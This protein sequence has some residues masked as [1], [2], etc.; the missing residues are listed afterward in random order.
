[1]VAFEDCRRLAIWAMTA[2]VALSPI[3]APAQNFY[4]GKTLTVIVGTDAGG[5]YDIYG[6]AIARHFGKHLAGKPTVIVQNMPGAGSA[7]AA[8]FLYNLA[9]KDGTNIGLIF[10]GIVVEPLLQPG[11][12]RFDPTKFEYL[13]SADSGTRL[14]VTHKSSKIKTFEDALKLP[15][16]FGGSAPGSS[17]TDYAHLLVNLAGAK[18]RV[19][20]GYKSSIDTVLAMERGEVD[21]ICGYDSSSFRAQKAEWFNTPE[22][23]MIVQA[24]LEPNEELT[25]LGVPHIWKYVS[26]ENRK[27]AEVVLAQQE[28][29]RPFVAPPGANSERLALLRTAFMAT[30]NDPEFLAD[31]K[32]MKLSITPKDAKTV[33]DLVNQMYAS[34]PDLVAKVNKALKP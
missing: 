5:G 33:T 26:G 22:A 23:H 16:T 32:K 17:T 11:K 34:P 3:A 8:E 14:C 6:R 13:G 10:P 24:A 7:K 12:F 27:I 29:H 18:M 4:E 30:M 31:A 28:F 19:V 15:S 2:A 21:G 9:P 20:N 25:K 1:M